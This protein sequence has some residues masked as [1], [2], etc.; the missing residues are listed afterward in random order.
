MFFFNIDN[1][2]ANKTIFLFC[3]FNETQKLVNKLIS[4]PM[5]LFWSTPIAQ[6]PTVKALFIKPSL[7]Y[8]NPF[9]KIVPENARIQLA[10]L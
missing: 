2:L 10:S 9:R 7:C 4:W 1:L 6:N 5:S 3:T 8:L